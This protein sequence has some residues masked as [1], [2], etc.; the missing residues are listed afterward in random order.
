MT[1]RIL[2]RTAGLLL[3]AAFACASAQ[4]QTAQAP[5]RMRIQ[6]AVPAASIY[7]CLLYTSD[8]ADEL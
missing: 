6:T 7:F 4:A 3:I 1:T 2:A 8:A 5:V